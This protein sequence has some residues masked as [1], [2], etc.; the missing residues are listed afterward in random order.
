MGRGKRLS[1]PEVT[2]DVVREMFDYDPLTCVLRRKKRYYRFQAGAIVGSKKKNGYIT[3]KVYSRYFACHRLAW[4][5]YYGEWPNGHIDHIN[6]N[7]SDNRIVNLRVVSDQQNAFN[8]KAWATNKSGFKG[9]TWKPRIKRWVANIHINNQQTHLGCFDT[10]EEA[11]AAY[12]A[13]A[14]EHFGEYARAG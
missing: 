8:R 4:A 3:T 13:A 7:P 6:G 1:A 11:H 12:M 10:P 2:I 9:V 5:H 14:R